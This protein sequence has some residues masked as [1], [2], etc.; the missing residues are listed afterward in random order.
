MSAW[1]TAKHR[2]ESHTE[3]IDGADYSQAVAFVGLSFSLSGH[4]DLADI[5][6][7]GRARAMSSPS[8][9]QGLALEAKL[10]ERLDHSA[11]SFWLN[12]SCVIGITQRSVSLPLFLSFFLFFSFLFFFFQL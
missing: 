7:A 11:N 5:C 3:K 2:W 4:G 8:P 10:P 1:G 6:R 12:L 9:T